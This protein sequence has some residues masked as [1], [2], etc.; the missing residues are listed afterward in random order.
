MKAIEFVQH[1]LMLMEKNESEKSP[2]LLLICGKI[3]FTVMSNLI[4]LIKEKLKLLKVRKSHIT[5]T[6]LLST[7]LVQNVFKH[8]HNNNLSN[9]FFAVYLSEKNKELILKSGN[10]IEK[11]KISPLDSKLKS[12][13]EKNPEEIKRIYLE[14]LDNNRVSAS[15]NA[16]LGLITVYRRARGKVSYKFDEIDNFL[17]YFVVEVKLDLK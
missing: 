4:E 2:E 6:K 3:D 8:G 16:G 9:S 11:N 15:D 17:S 14:K 10:L 12:Y 1:E 7:E 13:D 5:R